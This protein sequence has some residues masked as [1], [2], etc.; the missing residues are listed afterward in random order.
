MN[1]ETA[2]DVL[3]YDEPAPAKL[4]TGL[5]V[6]TILTFIGCAYELY[7]S[8]NSFLSGKKALAEMEKAQEKLAEAPAWARKFAGP[9]MMEMMQKGIEN[10]VPILIIG[11]VSIALC[12]YGAMEMRKLK[13]QG[14]T[15]WL[16]GEVL[17][18]VGTAIFVPAFFGTFLA[19]FIV[20]PTIFIILY[21]VQRKNLKY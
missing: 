17:P 12:V 15:L 6:L 18:Y 20:I 5:N 4:S 1:Q 8:V 13:K 2:N 9:E 7:N 11:L 16:I 19:F 10:R 21:T 14:Y 3:N